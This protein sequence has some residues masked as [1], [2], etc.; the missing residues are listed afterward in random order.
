M[1]SL[2]EQLQRA[3]EAARAASSVEAANRALVADM[4]DRW[5]RGEITTRQLRFRVE[6]VV[7]SAYRASGEI[8]RSLAEINS[9]IPGWKPSNATFRTDYLNSLQA[10]ARAAVSEYLKTMKRKTLTPE[11]A[12]KARA[13]VVMRVQHSAGVATTRGYTDGLIAAYQE[14]DREGVRVE[15]LWSVSFL[16]NTPCPRCMALHGE[17][18]RLNEPFVDLDGVGIYRDLMGPPRHP[19]CRCFLIILLITA[20][21]AAQTIVLDSPQQPASSMTADQVRKLPTPVYHSVLAALKVTAKYIR[22]S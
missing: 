19:R 8:G 6:A 17:R 7:R 12:A 5:S 10:D 1:V 11:D 15:K 16:N 4:I 9:D 2:D 18:A 3:R 14:L 22:R 13:R 20:E 21:N